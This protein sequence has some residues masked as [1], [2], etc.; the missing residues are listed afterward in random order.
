MC[1]S[2]VVFC[3]C[4]AFYSGRINAWKVIQ[5]HR[6]RNDKEPASAACLVTA[7]R[8]HNIP[9]LQSEMPMDACG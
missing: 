8:W 3:F 9:N 5:L 2:P 6:P 7:K 1:L 4:P